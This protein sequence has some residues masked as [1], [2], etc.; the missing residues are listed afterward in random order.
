MSSRLHLAIVG[1]GQTAGLHTEIMKRDRHCLDWVIG[2]NAQRTADFAA[3]HGFARH[4]SELGQA[5]DD[6]IVEA[7]LLCTPSAQ[8]AAQAAACLEAGK[9]VLV[10]IPLAMS[11]S[12]GR[13][14]AETARQRSLVLMVAHTT[15]F[16]ESMQRIRDDVVGG[17]LVFRS[18]IARCTRL[19]RENIGSSGYVR[20]WT[21]NLLWH[22]GQHLLDLILWFLAIDEPGRVDV[23]AMF[24]A[25]D[26][27]LG[28]PLDICVSL[29]TDRNQFGSAS[30]TYNS[31]V[32]LFDFVL[33]DD[34]ETLLIENGVLRNQFEVLLKPEINNARVLQDRE[35]VSAIHEARQPSINAN[36]VL[37]VLQVLQKADDIYEK[38]RAA[39][40]ILK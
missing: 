18:I 3:R 16:E 33:M 14:L 10:E 26:P 19:R 2:P 17:R 30:L 34:N 7:V 15:R 28:V 35:F 9:H 12:E 39:D 31:F 20:S 4:G 11:Y 24:A 22:H 36:A 29:R 25:P 37:P 5:L 27:K 8:H 13:L 23:T 40:T 32:D 38:W 21:D 6:P 1:Y